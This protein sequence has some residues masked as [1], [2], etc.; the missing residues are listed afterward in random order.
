MIELTGTKTY[1]IYE[2][3]TGRIVR[4]DMLPA[5][6]R[7]T[8]EL[9]RGILESDADVFNDFVQGKQ[10]QPRPRFDLQVAG[11]VL[12][13][14]PAGATVEIEGATYIADGSNI[15]LVF[16]FPGTYLVRVSL[17]PFHDEEVSIEN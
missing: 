6:M 16:N 14:V 2:L 7:P 1:V 5:I 11:N 8:L 17:W 10:V 9:K 15:E 13:G 12:S 3:A 4:K